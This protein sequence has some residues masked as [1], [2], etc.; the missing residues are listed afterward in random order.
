[1]AHYAGAH[2][3]TAILH[4]REPENRAFSIAAAIMEIAE[5]A[6]REATMSRGAECAQG[7]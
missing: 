6:Q 5:P 4:H 2:F 3:A 7:F 1:M